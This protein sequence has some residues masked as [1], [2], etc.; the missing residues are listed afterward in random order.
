MDAIFDNFIPF[1]LAFLPLF[2]AMEPI[3]VFP[4]YL[5]MTRRME[6]KEKRVVLFYSMLTATAITVAFLAA[7]RLLFLVLGITVADFQIAGGLILL[8]IAITDV[9]VAARVV[10]EVKHTA[11]VGIVPLGTPLIAGPAA[12]TTLLMLSDLYGFAVTFSALIANLFIVWFAF[13]SS[14]R[15]IN[16][17]G[18]RGALGI[19]K[20]ISLLLAAIAVMMIRRGIQSF[21][22]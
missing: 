1:S 19:S 5:S 13:Q 14:D 16:S 4:I 6:A 9:V 18:E 15:I 21:I 20:V 3:G 8:S 17:I 10:P 12:L 2:V 7:G 11:G 22:M